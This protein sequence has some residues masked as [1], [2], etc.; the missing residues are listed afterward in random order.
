[1]KS[2][3][4]KAPLVHPVLSWKNSVLL[5]ALHSQTAFLLLYKRRKMVWLRETILLQLLYIW[6]FPVCSS[7]KKYTCCWLAH[8][9]LPWFSVHPAVQC[10]QGGYCYSIIIL[11]IHFLSLALQRSPFLHRIVMLALHTKLVLQIHPLS[12]F[13][14]ARKWTV[15]EWPICQIIA[16]QY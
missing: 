12:P 2:T 10:F 14:I 1:M 7:W 4:C 9:Q 6:Y 13:M 16:H 15:D 3:L 8:G 5:L 11:L